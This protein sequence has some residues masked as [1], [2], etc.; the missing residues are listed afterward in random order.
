MF[1]VLKNSILAARDAIKFRLAYERQEG[2]LLGESSSPPELRGMFFQ[3]KML[4]VAD[5]LCP[6][7]LKQW[8]KITSSVNFGR[9]LLEQTFPRDLNPKDFHSTEFEVDLTENPIQELDWDD[10]DLRK[11]V[12]VS[13]GLY[14]NWIDYGFEDQAETRGIDPESHLF[15]YPPTKKPPS[16]TGSL[17]VKR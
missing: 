2:D 10:I 14:P 8:V 6:P 17:V 3:A 16:N 4:I 5:T 11:R 13:Q 9:H 15:Q 12:G 1:E 7:H